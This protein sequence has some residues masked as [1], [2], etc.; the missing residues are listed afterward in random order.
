MLHPRAIALLVPAL[1]LFPAVLFVPADEGAPP[2]IASGAV[3]G[4]LSVDVIA[5]RLAAPGA[6]EPFVPVAP[7]GLPANL[8]PYIPA[9]NPMTPAKVELGRQLYFDGRLSGDGTVSC[10][11]CHHP[12]MGFGD[13]RPVATGIDGQQGGVSSPTVM[14]R[15]FGKT[16]FWDGRAA[17][18]EEQA[19]GP[20]ENPIEMGFHFDQAVPLINGIEGYKMQF[21]AVFG[22]PATKLR[23]AQ[24]IATYERTVFSG[25]SPYDYYEAATPFHRL[26]VEDE[27]DPDTLRRWAEA[28][29]GELEHPMSE[30]ALNG[31]ELFFGKASC[32]SCHFGWDLSD[33]LFHNIG[34][35]QEGDSPHPGRMAVT[36]EAGD[37]GAFKTPG[38]H[39]IAF[40]APYMHDGSLLTLEEVIEHYD[41]GGTPNDNLSDKIFPLNL[42]AE[43]KVDLATFMREGLS[44]EVTGVEIPRLP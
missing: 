13:N 9:D 7:V 19:M 30:A 34:I 1:A 43:E 17:S 21:Q 28:I 16:Q 10:A 23:I 39:N 11:S 24:A 18:L 6:H 15:I 25:G 36:N 20:V 3:P 22:G 14:N 27:E 40:T 38:M 42:T 31:R 4:T 33:E 29:A 35:Q 8:A 44:G 37:K 32:S 12:A 41:V 2:L 26:D 5:R